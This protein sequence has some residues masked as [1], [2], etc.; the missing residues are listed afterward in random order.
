MPELD[1]GVDQVLV[2][3]DH[4]R[5]D[6]VEAGGDQRVMARH[7]VVEPE[8]ELGTGVVLPMGKSSDLTLCGHVEKRAE[9]HDRHSR[10]VRQS[11]HPE[12]PYVS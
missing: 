8:Q 12:Q 5:G 4:R 3:A 9:N 10:P 11:V 1:G 6:L 7:V 2:G